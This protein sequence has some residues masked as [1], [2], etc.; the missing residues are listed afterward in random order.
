MGAKK[1]RFEMT[2]LILTHI[3]RGENYTSVMP[4]HIQLCTQCIAVSSD[5]VDTAFV[6]VMFLGD[7]RFV[8]EE[9]SIFLTLF[10]AFWPT[11]AGWIWGEGNPIRY[12]DLGE[13]GRKELYIQKT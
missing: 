12:F 6:R 4:K 3:S 13:G 8:A 10:S 7:T 2:M 9:S 5:L 1:L 11:L